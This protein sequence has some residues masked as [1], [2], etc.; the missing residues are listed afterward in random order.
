[1]SSE[2]GVE[3]APD[4]M[5][6]GPLD[7]RSQRL[8]SL[9]DRLRSDRVGDLIHLPRLVV[10]GDQSSGKSSVLNAISRQKFPTDDL[11][12][13]RYPH[14]LDMRPDSHDHITVSIVPAA[15]R[16]IA[17]QQRLQAFTLTPQ[18]LID[19]PTIVQEA[20]RLMGLGQEGG[21]A[22][23]KDT[24]RIAIGGP[25]LP[26]LTVVDLPG[27]FHSGVDSQTNDDA[28]FVKELV[29][30]YMK[31]PR[32]IILAVV[33]AKNDPVNQIV[34]KY[35]YDAD[36]TH[37][38]TL[39][40]ITKPDLTDSPGLTNHILKMAKN[41]VRQ[42][43]LGW[44]VL[45][46]RSYA[47]RHCSDDARDRSEIE[48]FAKGVWTQLPRELKGIH[49][50]KCRLSSIYHDSFVASIPDLKRDVEQA[51]STLQNRLQELEDSSV[52]T[53]TAYAHR[54]LYQASTEFTKAITE[55][56]QK[57]HPPSR[58]NSSRGAVVNVRSTVSDLVH[59]F[60]VRLQRE[61]HAYEL[62]EDSVTPDKHH[63]PPQIRHC[64][65]AGE[66]GQRVA[67]SDDIPYQFNPDLVSELFYDR[68]A[69]W[70]H[71][72]QEFVADVIDAIRACVDSVLHKT[73]RPELQ[74]GI[75]KV[76]ISPL[77]EALH[78]KMQSIVDEKIARHVARAT[79][80]FDRTVTDLIL[81]TRM[82]ED[83]R[84]VVLG[85]SKHFLSK[86]E[87]TPKRPRTIYTDVDVDRLADA[88]ME[89]W[90]VSRTTGAAAV[91][92]MLA[93]YEVCCWLI[94]TGQS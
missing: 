77:M 44:H 34:L 36:K 91:R 3:G 40:I 94:T 90:D 32:T 20:G 26:P 73:V 5:P 79:I 65:F 23:S 45:K 57:Q 60:K 12:C 64:D 56:V 13:T 11:L 22:F 86:E 71:I 6:H 66:V 89:M 43:A 38:R 14:E 85:I 37:K 53:R 35:A 55:A 16:S 31:A 59:R 4:E 9:V 74:E 28:E 58:R 78:N 15:G 82:L 49:S 54:D 8:L 25:R 75:N 67:D 62:I 2:T 76:I 93:Y 80:D 48:F 92:C 19:L 39:G 68:S 52:S 61:G 47:D 63:Q 83:R 42:L 29:Q 30:G 88:V 46:N 33:S 10:C 17:E 87:T 70:P 21:P 27:L 18:S 69:P 81:P 51:I 1:M 72:I 24:L 7:A 84:S 50:L 41:E